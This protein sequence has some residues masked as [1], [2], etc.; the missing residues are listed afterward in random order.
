MV[1]KMT[2]NGPRKRRNRLAAIVLAATTLCGVAGAS[3]YS[4]LFPDVDV[5]ALKKEVQDKSLAFN[6]DPDVERAFSSI[7]RGL[8][9]LEV[10][11]G[12]TPEI[13]KLK[14]DAV[15]IAQGVYKNPD[16]EAI[17]RYAFI[18]QGRDLLRKSGGGQ[19][20]WEATAASIDR[21]S[22][23]PYD[24]IVRLVKNVDDPGVKGKYK[25]QIY[26]R[27]SFF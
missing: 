1:T 14:Q 26:I 15:A 12:R 25:G 11:G 6:K 21:F 23:G 22:S 8:E 2:R 16:E 5:D 27:S 13:E 10:T 24:A 20:D 3:A 17:K 9:A 7:R 18:Q 19:Y 4:V